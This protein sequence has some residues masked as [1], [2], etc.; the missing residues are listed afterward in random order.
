MQN[1][2]KTLHSFLVL[3]ASSVLCCALA[4]AENNLDAGGA[5]GRL[6]NLSARAQVRTGDNVLIAGVIIGGS[7]P[8]QVLFRAIGA[9]LSTNGT[10]F[11][12]RLADPVLSLYQ[13]G[14][15]T[16]IATNDNWKD[17]Q[18]AE[19][20]AT[21][22]QPGSDLD[23]AILMTLQ[24]GNYTTILRGKN[25]GTGIALIEAYETDAG[26]PR[27]MNVSARGP[28]ETGDNVMIGGFIVAPT[29]TTGDFPFMVR[30]IGPSL[31]QYGIANPVQDPMVQLFDANGVVIASNDD[32][33]D[34]P[35]EDIQRSGLAPKDDRE[36]VILGAV[37]PGA[38]TAIMRG[39][40]QASGTGL[41]EIYDASNFAMP[42]AR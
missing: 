17:T 4:H 13:E 3:T 31:A 14:S 24:P 12:G 15:A 16:P 10:P 27:L 28:D 22:R 20:T 18:Q 6:Q 21:G 39:K 30:A 1:P 36:S 26:N 5:S 8:K 23:S 25:G 2:M 29:A 9:S 11:P 41:I 35:F 38:Y 40:N 7:E 37:A 19:I 42:L 32:W 34:G 33:R